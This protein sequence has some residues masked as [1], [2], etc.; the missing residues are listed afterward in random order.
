M[1]TCRLQVVSYSN[2]PKSP[3]APSKF[4]GLKSSHPALVN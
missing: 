4:S 2:D 1:G 3:S